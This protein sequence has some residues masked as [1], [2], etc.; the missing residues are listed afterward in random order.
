M[1]IWKGL[2]QRSFEQTSPPRGGVDNHRR[3]SVGERGEDIFF[4]AWMS[5]V[6]MDH[7]HVQRP[8]QIYSGDAVVGCQTEP[9]QLLFECRNIPIQEVI[10]HEAA[11]FLIGIIIEQPSEP[12]D[13]SLEE[14]PECL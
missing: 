11:P 4:G 9:E 7:Q 6:L 2:V 13:H 10:A 8:F 3:A 5:G 12:A 14:Y 1:S